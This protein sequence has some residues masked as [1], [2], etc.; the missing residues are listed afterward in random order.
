VLESNKTL[1]RFD[2]SGCNMTDSSAKV[3]VENLE[4]S[5][6]IAFVDF[7]FN[8][9]RV[10]AWTARRCASMRVTVMTGVCRSRQKPSWSTR[11]CS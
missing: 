8:D 4:F 3:L 11:R 7:S 9:V 10:L 5:T 2:M 1:K 6:N